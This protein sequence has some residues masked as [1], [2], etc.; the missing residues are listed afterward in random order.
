VHGTS[1]VVLL[2]LTVAALGL[3][4]RTGGPDVVRRRA[5]VL[6]TA[7]LANATIGYVQYFTGVPVLLVGFHI[8]GA[9]CV[10]SAAVW[11]L[12][13]TAGGRHHDAPAAAGL[14]DERRVERDGVPAA[15]SA[16]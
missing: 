4:H 11:L 1:V 2:L 9:V 15:Q 12:L 13:G 7:I 16:Y 3:I 6:V 14:E 10:W 8:A 5:A